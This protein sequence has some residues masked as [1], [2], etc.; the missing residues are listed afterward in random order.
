MKRVLSI[1]VM[2]H[3][4]YSNAVTSRDDCLFVKLEL[5]YG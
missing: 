4:S 1:Y 3:F 2:E 5:V